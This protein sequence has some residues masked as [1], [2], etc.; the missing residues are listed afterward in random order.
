MRNVIP[1]NVHEGV[2]IFA[3]EQHL[4]HV[5]LRKREND[6][7]KKEYRDMDNIQSFTPVDMAQMMAT[8]FF[9]NYD[10]VEVLHDPTKLKKIDRSKFYTSLD[11]DAETV[12]N[13]TQLEEAKKILA[14]ANYAKT[15]E[16][17]KEQNAANVAAPGAGDV[18]ATSSPSDPHA[19][20]TAE[21]MEAL[22]AKE[23]KELAAARKEYKKLY[24]A[25]ADENATLEEL[26]E[27]I[28]SKYGENK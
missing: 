11:E 8:N 25:D 20:K 2:E 16:A 27:L 5:L 14:D 21:E 24:S 1:A 22:T 12:A 6:P 23:K 4:F 18:F 13:D 19:G 10:T 28:N 17:L 15:H 7:V 26:T 3:D 9:Q